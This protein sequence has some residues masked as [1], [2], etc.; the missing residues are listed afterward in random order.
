MPSGREIYRNVSG[1]S[2]PVEIRAGA[3]PGGGAFQLTEVLITR[4]QAALT[5][6]KKTQ[7]SEGKVASRLNQ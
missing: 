7:S 4:E 6:D 2:V 3:V 1:A 5:G